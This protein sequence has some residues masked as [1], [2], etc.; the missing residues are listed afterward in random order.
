MENNTKCGDKAFQGDSQER[1]T[2]SKVDNPNALNRKF[3]DFFRNFQKVLDSS[4]LDISCELD[5]WANH[6]SDLC[7]QIS[8]INSLKIET[9]TTTDEIINET[10]CLR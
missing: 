8:L 3:E 10:N 9:E 2:N 1:L 7:S 6:E 5:T 4:F